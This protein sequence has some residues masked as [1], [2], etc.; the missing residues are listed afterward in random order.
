MCPAE[1]VENAAPPSPRSSWAWVRS[2]RWDAESLDRHQCPGRCLRTE[3][4]AHLEGCF[5]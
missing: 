4:Y 2:V 3:S 1:R 5:R